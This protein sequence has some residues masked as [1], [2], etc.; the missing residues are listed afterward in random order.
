M[1]GL[2]LTTG[3]LCPGSDFKSFAAF[4]IR[5]I[6]ERVLFVKVG[7]NMPARLNEPSFN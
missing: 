6:P 3:R 1:A 7:G 5:A 2:G 4:D